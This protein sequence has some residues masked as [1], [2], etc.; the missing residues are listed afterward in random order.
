[1][2]GKRVSDVPALYLSGPLFEILSGPER[3]PYWPTS[4]IYHS[5]PIIKLHEST[6]QSM[7]EIQ[8]HLG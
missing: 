7:F 1:M 2:R 4:N 8:T 3:Q 5:G 6:P